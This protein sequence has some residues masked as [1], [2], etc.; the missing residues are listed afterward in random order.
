MRSTMGLNEIWA[1]SVLGTMNEIVNTNNET[2]ETARETPG[3][4]MVDGIKKC[5]TRRCG[6]WLPTACPR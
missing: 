4:A 6:L 2:V 5:H 1:R 3:A